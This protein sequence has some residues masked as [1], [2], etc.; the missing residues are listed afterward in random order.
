M[1]SGSGD[2]AVGWVHGVCDGGHFEWS[3][4]QN[5]SRIEGERAIVGGR[6]AGRQWQ[7]DTGWQWH[8]GITSGSGGVAVGAS[9]ELRHCGNF[10]WSEC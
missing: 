7:W 1:G 9:D 6:V 5:P 3:E 8:G 10:E 2:V 4:R